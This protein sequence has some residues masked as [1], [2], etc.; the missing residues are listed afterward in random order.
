M[1]TS[2]VPD[3]IW[4]SHPDVQGTSLSPQDDNPSTVAAG[5]LD[6]EKR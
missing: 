2:I 3:L 5:G 1:A 6:P 4:P